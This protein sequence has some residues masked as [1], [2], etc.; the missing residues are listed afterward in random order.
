MI[1]SFRNEYAFLSNM[2]PA[3]I[4]VNGLRF[5]CAEAVFQMMKTKNPEERVR[6]VNIS[7][8]DAK[9]LGRC[10]KLRPDWEEIKIKVMRWVIHLKFK[11]PTLRQKLLD[12]GDALLIEGNDWEDTFWGVCNGVGK[13]WLG[14]ILM[15]ERSAIRAERLQV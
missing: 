11:E 10:V 1:K 8:K 15:E 5:T 12:T 13:N 14:K 4:V 3:P 9:R 6:F 2:Y 7:G